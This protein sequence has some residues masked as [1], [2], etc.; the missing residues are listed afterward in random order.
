MDALHRKLIAK[1]SYKTKV[2]TGPRHAVFHPSMPYLF[3]VNELVSSLS[4][5]DKSKIGALKK[6]SSFNPSR[7]LSVIV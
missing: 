6:P 7:L 4:S 1:T 3:V 2:G 5:F